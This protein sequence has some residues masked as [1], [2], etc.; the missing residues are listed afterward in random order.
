MTQRLV[1]W[2]TNPESGWKTSHFWGPLANWGLVVAAIYDATSKGADIISMP[3]TMSMVAYSALF[4][5][6]A[7]VVQ[8]R[9]YLLLSC[10]ACNEMAQL[11]QLRRA[12]DFQQTRKR[13]T[14]QELDVDFQKVFAGIAAGAIA[15]VFGP[16]LQ[17]K[18]IQATE[19]RPHGFLR[20]K[21]I[22]HPAGP[23]SSMFWAPTAKWSLSASNIADYNRPVDKVS[24]AQQTAL[25]LTGFIWMRYSL[26]IYP[27]NYNL[28]AVNSVL[29]FTGAYQLFRKYQQAS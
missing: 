2:I 12:F 23:F 22:L 13:E 5:R 18:L 25:T 17:T 16:R 4:M 20:E 6:F 19:H 28:F 26:V 15:T 21:V 3:M 29:G 8:P 9:N 1:R 10:H 7:W 24:F 14:G 27:V 11:N